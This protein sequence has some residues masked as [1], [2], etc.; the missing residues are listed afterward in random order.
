M[1]P[2][3]VRG[4]GVDRRTDVYAA[5]IVLWEALTERVLFDGANEAVVLGKVMNAVPVAP[6][7]IATDV[8]Q[9]LDVIVLRALA[10]DR[11]DRYATAEEMADILEAT[12]LAAS[13][14]EVADWVASLAGVEIQK[15]ADVVANIELATMPKT[16]EQEQFP[17]WTDTDTETDI[18][19]EMRIGARPSIERMRAQE[20]TSPESAKNASPEAKAA[21]LPSG[22][23][24]PQAST[25]RM[26]RA[27]TSFLAHDG[28]FEG[29]RA[30]RRRL[31]IFALAG[32]GAVVG[33][34]TLVVLVWPRHRQEVTSA[35]AS[36]LPWKTSQK[37]ADAASTTAHD[38]GEI[39]CANPYV[40]DDSGIHRFR[41]ECQ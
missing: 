21:L 29:R 39:N 6:S 22:P 8:P 25:G 26:V 16:S 11:D 12:Q 7:E 4:S 15:R 19:L 24:E 10:R 36:P 20:A 14:N 41:R 5:A 18:E 34:A 1:A 9:I 2:E 37:P 35:A 3:Q 33:V 31:T 30:E 23:S 17:V 38:G 13:R 40:I 28:E 27:R 32:A